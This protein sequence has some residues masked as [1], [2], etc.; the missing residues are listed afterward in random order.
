MTLQ[1]QIANLERTIKGLKTA[2]T[3]LGCAASE[4]E[5]DDARDAGKIDFMRRDL[6]HIIKRRE[7][8][9][10]DL[11]RQQREANETRDQADK[12]VA[13]LL[14]LCVA[15][16]ERWCICKDQETKSET[17]SVPTLCGYFIAL[18]WGIERHEST[19]PECIEKLNTKG[20]ANAAKE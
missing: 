14:P 4:S 6:W 18:P 12:I 5:W 16:R 2:A 8:R 17:E 9:L 1:T 10:S 7:S 3:E 20:A 15:S 11:E 19:C 13:K